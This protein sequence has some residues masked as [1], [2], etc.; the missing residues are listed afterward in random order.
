MFDFSVPCMPVIVQAAN[1][2][3]EHP[4]WCPAVLWHEDC[5]CLVPADRCVRAQIEA[6]DAKSN[7]LTCFD[8]ANEV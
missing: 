3:P 6:L 8:V 5:C 1:R 2:G 4:L 7:D